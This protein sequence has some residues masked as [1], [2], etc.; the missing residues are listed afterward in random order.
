MA[1]FD[2]VSTP[3]GAPLVALFVNRAAHPVRILHVDASGAEVPTLS[4]RVGEHGEV[5]A[6]TTHAWRARSQSGALLLELA[7]TPPSPDEDEYWG[8]GVTTI[9]VP[10]CATR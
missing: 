8:T 4:L 7:S 10:P 2:L 5:H 3:G 6:R 9:H 1:Q